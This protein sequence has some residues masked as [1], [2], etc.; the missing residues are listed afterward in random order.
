MHRHTLVSSAAS[1]FIHGGGFGAMWL[2]NELWGNPVNELERK[3]LGPRRDMPRG[4]EQDKIIHDVRRTFVHGHGSGF[5]ATQKE[6]EACTRRDVANGVRTDDFVKA[7][8]WCR[9]PE[10]RKAIQ[11]IFTKTTNDLPYRDVALLHPILE[12]VVAH[13][14]RVR[15]V[16]N[17]SLLRPER[18]RRP[19]SW[20]E[21]EA[22]S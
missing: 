11:D 17:P 3:T 15:Q 12:P 20:T 13:A 19:A 21:T 14:Q 2:D 1:G 6:V 16:A 18:L 5:P 22:E 7:V 10:V 8:S 9:E 4:L